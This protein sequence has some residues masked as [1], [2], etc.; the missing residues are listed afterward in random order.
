MAK[1]NVNGYIITYMFVNIYSIL[2]L[3]DIKI[4]P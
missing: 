3:R 2:Q 4:S 1:N